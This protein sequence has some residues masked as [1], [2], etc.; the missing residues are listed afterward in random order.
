MYVPVYIHIDC[1]E[2]CQFK[3]Y[4]HVRVHVA[5]KL[6]GRMFFND[7]GQIGQRSR[8]FVAWT[9][10]LPDVEFMASVI[11]SFLGP[12]QLSVACN[13]EEQFFS[14]CAGRAWERG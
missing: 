10:G 2:E 7:V 14:L 11:A 9:L 8:T 3:S 12:A 13:T 1:A 4:T 5:V 6:A